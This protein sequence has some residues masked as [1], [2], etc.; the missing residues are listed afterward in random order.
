[1]HHAGCMKDLVG[2]ESISKQGKLDLLGFEVSYGSVHG[3][4]VEVSTL[5]QQ[6]GAR[7]LNGES[8]ALS[9]SELQT[10]LSKHTGLELGAIQ[11]SGGWHV[12]SRTDA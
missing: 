7:L 1:M 6:R 8:S 12:D 10:A 2:S 3:W 4:T 9:S 5:P 11:P